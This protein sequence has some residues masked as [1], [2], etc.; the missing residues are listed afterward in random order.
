MC[1]GSGN[2]WSFHKINRKPF[3]LC[4]FQAIA[5]LN[6][7]QDSELQ[8]RSPFEFLIWTDVMDSVHGQH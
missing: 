3:I 6:V 2:W 1:R 5:N 7:W 8:V 4:L